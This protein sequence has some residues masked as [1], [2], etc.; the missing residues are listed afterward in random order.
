MDS[1]TGMANSR[2]TVAQL[3]NLLGSSS[4]LSSD[5]SVNTS[6]AIVADIPRIVAVLLLQT[7]RESTKGS[8][9]LRKKRLRLSEAAHLTWPEKN[10]KALSL[11][12]L[13]PVL[14]SVQ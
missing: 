5:E 14:C 2:G 6:I 8:L 11:D 9:S 4:I 1:P 3:A 12:W 10:Q 13:V 7:S